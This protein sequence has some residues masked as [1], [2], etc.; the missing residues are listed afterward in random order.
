MEI[1]LRELCQADIIEQNIGSSSY[2]FRHGMTQRAV[3]ESLARLVR[4]KLHRTAAEYWAKQPFARPLRVAHHWLNGGMPL[5]AIE[6]INQAAEAAEA[7]HD[8]A[9]AIELYTAA[10]EIL[11]S[12]KSWR[13]QIERL[14][15]TPA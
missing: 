7:K 14:Q 1:I 5:R 3:Y 12:E 13:T 2:R 9:G 10:L 6:T 15:A 8:N 4:Q 11:P